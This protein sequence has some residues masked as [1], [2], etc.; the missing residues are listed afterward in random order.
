MTSGISPGFWK[1]KSLPEMTRQEWE[2]LCDGCGLC[3]LHK[4]EDE[5]SHEVSYTN[6][7][8][9]LLDISSCRC[10]NYPRRRTL[11]PDCVIL[12]PDLL[13]EFHWLP[14]S[15]AYR[16]LHEGRDLAPWHPL[17]SGTNESV[18]KAGISV[19]GRVVA[20]QDAGNL[21][22][23]IM[24]DHIIDDSFLKKPELKPELKDKP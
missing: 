6:V 3:C 10:K 15:C 21:Q 22:D 23:H 12:T 8:C 2:S 24:P 13:P 11:V 9:R 20:E 4:L 5:D 7:A 16:S 1:S 18:H 19:R 17:L 14:E